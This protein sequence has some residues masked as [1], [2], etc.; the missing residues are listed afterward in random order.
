M[1]IIFR[2]DA[3]K[4]IG[5]GHLTRCITLADQ[6]RIKGAEVIFIC[7]AEEKTDY[8]I[9]F[10][11]GYKV[12]LLKNKAKKYDERYNSWLAVNWEEDAEE[13]IQTINYLNQDIDLIIVDHYGIDARW[14]RKLRDSC[15]K[16]FV[17]DDLADRDLDCDFLLNSSFFDE[18]EDYGSLLKNEKCKSFLGPDYALVSA[19]YNQLRKEALIK[20]KNRG[21]IS[22][23][24]VFLGSM[25]PDNYSGI[26]IEA[27]QSFKWPVSIEVNCILSA[28]SP[29]LG[30]IKEQIERME[31]DYINPLFLKD[32]KV[33]SQS[34][35]PKIKIYSDTKKMEQFILNADLCIGSGGNSAWERCVLGLPTF[36]TSIAPNQK[37]N[38]QSI[39]KSGA[40]DIWKSKCD[41][42]NL[43]NKY[44]ENEEK[45]ISLQKNAF[46]LCDGLGLF[47]I[48]ESII[49]DI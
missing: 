43:F 5:N 4:R 31:L 37:R 18:K 45:L 48:T 49:R 21:S 15:K 20:R 40:A 19:K 17:I 14:H 25:D 47:R 11:S 10:N 8:D 12:E 38:I 13:V 22:E 27:I 9:L 46:N 23:I 26:A 44:I 1:N 34:Y 16:I 3:S 36:L 42:L 28:N 24:L 7:R 30:L 2:L 41:L 32:N 39:S 6:L 29:S 33:K 35:T